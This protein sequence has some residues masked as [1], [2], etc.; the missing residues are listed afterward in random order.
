MRIIKDFNKP[1]ILLSI[2]TSSDKLGNTI[3]LLRNS[4][5]IKNEA[6]IILLMWKSLDSD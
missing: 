1:T 2:L 5:F 3:R 4:S 6:T